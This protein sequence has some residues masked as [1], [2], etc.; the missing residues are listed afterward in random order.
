M[1]QQRRWLPVV[2]WI[3]CFPAE[4]AANFLGGFGPKVNTGAGTAAAEPPPT[5]GGGLTS[6]EVRKMLE[7]RRALVVAG[8]DVLIAL[9]VAQGLVD[10]GA[11]VTLACQRPDRIAKAVERL[12]I[13]N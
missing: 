13:R 8:E 4:I 9:E 7:H 1:P 11:C 2:V 5:V 3:A 12:S 6:E 10:V